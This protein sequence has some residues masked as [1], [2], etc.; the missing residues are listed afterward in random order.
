M[1]DHPAADWWLALE[2][3]GASPE[4]A[5]EAVLMAHG[6]RSEVMAALVGTGLAISTTEVILDG[7]RSVAVRR[8]WISA[9]GRKIIPT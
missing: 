7:G 5:T 9:R 8:F 2:L 1:P 3:L 6:F 4:G